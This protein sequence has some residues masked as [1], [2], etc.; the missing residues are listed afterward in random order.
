MDRTS[1]KEGIKGKGKGNAEIRRTLSSR[2]TPTPT[3]M[4]KKTTPSTSYAAGGGGGSSYS[5]GGL[6]AVDVHESERPLYRSY[7]PGECSV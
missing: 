6:R 1:I 2:F 3:T 7:R 5:Q 4:A